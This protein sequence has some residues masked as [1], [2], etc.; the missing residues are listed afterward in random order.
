MA[1]V[2]GF[3]PGDLIT[4]DQIVAQ[5]SG[6]EI[7]LAEVRQVKNPFFDDGSGKRKDNS[8]NVAFV[9]AKLS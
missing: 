7:E 4:R 3:D 9:R 8:A 6:M 5:L 1:Q 2:W